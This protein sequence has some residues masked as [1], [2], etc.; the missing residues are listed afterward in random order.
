VELSMS[1][2]TGKRCFAN[3][4][5]IIQ[6]WIIHSI[7]IPSYSLRVGYLLVGFSLRCV[8]KFSVKRI[9]CRETTRNSINNKSFLIFWNDLMNLVDPFR[10]PNDHRLNLSHFYSAMVA[11]SWTSCTYHFFFGVNICN[12]FHPTIKNSK[13]K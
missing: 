3:I 7:I 10:R 6:Y 5:T 2:S 13:L 8:W 4:I 1:K 12:A 9:F 11:Y